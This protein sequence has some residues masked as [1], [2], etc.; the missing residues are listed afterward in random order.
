MKKRK[1]QKKILLF[2]GLILILLSFA[3]AALMV[4]LQYDELWRWYAVTRQNLE[5]LEEYILHINITWQFLFISN[6]R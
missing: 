6:C 4:S 5:R 2:G 1:K 3:V